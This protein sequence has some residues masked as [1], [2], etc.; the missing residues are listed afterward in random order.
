MAN[1][2][3]WS[4]LSPRERRVRLIAQAT[5]SESQLKALL[6]SH[7]RTRDQFEFQ[8]PIATFWVDFLF[9]REKLVVELDGAVHSGWEAK[10]ADKRRTRILNRAGYRVIRFW[11]GDLRQPTAVMVAI[12]NA[13]EGRDPPLIE[14]TV[15]LPQDAAAGIM[16]E[17]SVKPRK[18]SRKLVAPKTATKKRR[19]A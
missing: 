13:L 15:Y 10:A 3:P 5:P 8:A 7:L 6:N 1:P 19:T 11:N 16:I 12:L 2:T 9:P 17:T 4:D 18:P 14:Q